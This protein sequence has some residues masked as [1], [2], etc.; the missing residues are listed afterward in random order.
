MEKNGTLAS[1]A[2]AR[3]SIVLP[4]HG[5]PT[6]K[7][8]FG[9]LAPKDAIDFKTQKELLSYWLRR[10]GLREF[11][12]KQIERTVNYLKVARSGAI[13]E[14][15]KGYTFDIDKDYLALRALER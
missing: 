15:S 3:E 1:P 5:G 6:S 2:T 11:N 4:V 12:L 9:I 10:K 13:I 14:V 7:T 8:P